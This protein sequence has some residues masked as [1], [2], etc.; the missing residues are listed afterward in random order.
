MMNLNPSQKLHTTAVH[1]RYY[2]GDGFPFGITKKTA[3]VGLSCFNPLTATH[4]NDQKPW[5][6]S[7]IFHKNST[8]TPPIVQK[9]V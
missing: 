3:F 8:I 9:Y 2:K 7:T 6:R 1:P 5:I 4:D